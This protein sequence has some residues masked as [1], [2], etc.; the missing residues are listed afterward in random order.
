LGNTLAI[1]GKTEESAAELGKA[2]HFPGL[3]SGL[4]VSILNCL[5]HVA[6][7]EGRTGD[8]I[9]YSSQSLAENAAQVSA[10]WL[11][12]TFLMRESDYRGALGQ[13]LDIDAF[14]RNNRHS[15]SH[16][17]AFDASVPEE[18]LATKIGVCHEGLGDIPEALGSYY[19][20]LRAKEGHRVALDRYL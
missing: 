20:A 9:L 7:K 2:L 1:L 8:G 16:G 14:Q 19:R 4:R 13:F 11:L 3:T 5:A 6:A 12:A 18:E 15:Q 10:R 17:Q